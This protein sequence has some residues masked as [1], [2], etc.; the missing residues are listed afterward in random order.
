LIYFTAT[1]I[2][3][4]KRQKPIGV[5]FIIIQDFLWVIG[6]IVL[7][8]FQPFEISVAG[9]GIIAAV[10]LVV[11]FM[12]FNQ[13]KT[14]GQIDNKSSGKIKQLRFERTTQANK[15]KV[16]EVISDV[17]NYH[18]VA[19]NIDNVEIISGT[20]EGMIR[21]CSH[22]KESWTETCSL[23]IE[24]KE[25]AFEVNTD[26]ADYPYPFK[27]LKGNWKI[28]ETNSSHT[29]IIMLFEFEY[30]KKFQNWLLHPILKRKFSK[31]AEELLDNWQKKIKK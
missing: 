24:E 1:I 31:T 7:L 13:A 23:W 9:N 2:Y 21:S 17:A 6:S 18:E 5:L 12:G 15:A 10:A 16:W 8:I 20:E 19:P 27:Y 30:E 28:E 25:Y 22:G 4:I 14:L 11:L 26:A 29:K 3:E